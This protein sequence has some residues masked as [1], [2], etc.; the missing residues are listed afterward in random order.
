[1]LMLNSM[2]LHLV[3]LVSLALLTVS[4]TYGASLVHL[5]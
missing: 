5:V 3:Y 2:E 1:M 4:L